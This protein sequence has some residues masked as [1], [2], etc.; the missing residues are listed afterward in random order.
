MR[1]GTQDTI[2]VLD[3]D[4]KHSNTWHAGAEQIPRRAAIG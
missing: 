4:I 3:C 1:R 2:G